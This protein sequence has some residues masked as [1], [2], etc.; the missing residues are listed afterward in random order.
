MKTT[1]LRLTALLSVAV[2]STVACRELNEPE[3]QSGQ[4]L[5][6][7]EVSLTGADVK[8]TMGPSANNARKVYWSDGDCM[9]LNGI[10]ST[11]LANVPAESQTATFTFS[12]TQSTPYKFLYPA[13]FYKNAN[14]ITLPATQ[15]FTAGTFA[16]ATEPLCGYSASATNGVG[17]NHLCS[18]IQL[19]IKKAAGITSGT[20]QKIT[21]KGNNGE[22]VS[23]DF[24]IDYAAHT[25]TGASS[26]DASKS[27]A[28]TLSQTL[29][30][31]QALNVYLVV[32]A[33]EYSNGFYV[34]VENAD[35]KVTTKTAVDAATLPAGKLVRMTEFTFTPGNSY[36]QI[37]EIS[38][39]ILEPQDYNVKGR[40]VDTNGNPLQDVVVSDGLQ[41]VRTMVNGAF[42]MKSNISKLTFVQV[43]TPKGYMPKV[44]NGIPKYYK[45]KAAATVSGGV[46]N[47]GDF[48]L[49]PMS[50]P[51]R[52]TILVTADPQ[53]RASDLSLDNVAYR[54]LRGCECMYLDLTE[55]AATM[56]DRQVIGICLGDLV[57]EDMDLMDTYATA[58]GTLGYPTYNIIGNHDYDTSKADDDAGAWKFEALFGPRNYSFNMGNYHFV[59][60][61][62]LI[63]KKEGGKL[64]AYDNGLSDEVWTW[65]QGDMAF[66]PRDSEVWVFAHSAMFKQNNGNERTNTAKH[67]GHTNASEGGAFGYG[68]LFDQYA[69]V[70]AWAGHSHKGFDYIYPQS[71]RHKNVEVHTVARST[72]ELW[73]NEYMSGGIPR[74]FTIVEFEGGELA[75][76]RFHPTKYLKSSFHGTHGQPTYTYCDWTYTNT[77]PAVA[78]M[79]DTGLDLD[80]SYQMHVYKPAD[81]GENTIY[82]NI[83]LWDKAWGMPTLSING[84]TPEEMILVND[85]DDKTKV[86]GVG[87]DMGDKEIT[88]FYYTNYSLLRAAGY[89]AFEPGTPLTIFKAASTAPASGTGTV[90]VTDR[91]GQVFTR[92]ISW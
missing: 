56:T 4:E 85:L 9:S 14:T 53:P 30:E 45:A 86:P 10:A 81:Y 37:E 25:L 6:T 7:I 72:G 34:T 61:D 62:D 64:S 68:D 46:Y 79:K 49:T 40:V 29:S 89:D 39:S 18:V 60:L 38:E 42:F 3:K 5:T 22:Q 1:V 27:V 48:V 15:T 44:E 75:S 17:L 51:D 67:G 73:T 19:S 88:D 8:T 16:T 58:L 78:K 2:L 13:S 54:S 41:S 74:G 32:P 80:E 65:L 87:Y 33:G 91:F 20:I 12:G 52:F 59:V 70:Y 82:A 90:T 21:F 55:T 71:H 84:G 23:G 83:F 47:F 28:L 36:F 63:M 43:S 57:H 69:R 66:I 26:A 50:N 35:H 24:T 92:T 31:T 77:S 11:P 76:W